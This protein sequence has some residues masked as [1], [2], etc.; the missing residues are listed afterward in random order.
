MIFPIGDENVK[1]GYK[2]IFSYS[3]IATNVLLY[4]ISISGGVESY[5]YI[6]HTFGA[7][8][9]EVLAGED[10]LSLVTNMFL[11]GGIGHLLFNMIFLWIFADNIEAVIGN[12]RF[13][14]FYILGG[15]VASLIH[16]FINPSS[17]I[18]SIGASGAIA[19]VMGAYIVMFPKSKIKMFFF[20][21]IFYISAYIFLGIW[22]VQQ[23]FSGFSDL[24]P[25]S[26]QEGGTAWWAHIGGFVFGVASGYLFKRLGYMGNV[27][28]NPGDKV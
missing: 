4:I 13:L 21:K 1:G 24:G 27:V 3:F 6:V 16:V 11:H 7:I 9:T 19:A 26:A 18:P 12:S 25:G 23:L 5:R 17:S 22:I 8:P 2:P 15:I 14:I 10:Y 20:F 28:Y